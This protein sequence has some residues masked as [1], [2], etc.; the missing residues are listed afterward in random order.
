[1]AALTAHPATDKQID[2]IKSLIAER[3]LS[4]I[5]TI[6]HERGG[7]EY[8]STEARSAVETWRE[9]WR[10]HGSGVFT[11]TAASELIGYL[12]RAPRK[13]EHKPN[14]LQLPEV[15]AGRYAMPA[16][17]G[18][19]AFFRVSRPTEGQWAGMT[20]LTV[21]ASDTEYPI[22]SADARRAILTRIAEDPAAASLRYGRE[23]GACG[24]CGRTL[25]D[26]DSRAR[27]I[28]PVCAEKTGW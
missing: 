23:I 1:M 13:P 6:N 21:Q 12:L 15:P 5:W 20:F 17:D 10:E 24:I 11:T 9:M 8:R 2:F 22:R 14:D 26:E 25:T 27:G 19:L 16:K 3:D 18:H 4:L 28:G 7:P